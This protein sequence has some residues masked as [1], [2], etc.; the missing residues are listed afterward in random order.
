MTQYKHIAIDPKVYELI[1]AIAITQRRTIGAQVAVIVDEWKKDHDAKFM[2]MVRAEM[3][4]AR[5]QADTYKS[6]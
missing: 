6:L 1:A 3:E 5:D 4:D 2:E